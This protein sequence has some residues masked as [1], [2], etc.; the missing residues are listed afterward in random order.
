M[1]EDNLDRQIDLVLQQMAG[2]EGPADLRR[3][4][5]ERVAEPRRRATSRGAVLAAAATILL[6]VAMA[7]VLRRVIVHP[8]ATISAQRDVPTAAATSPPA[9]PSAGASRPARWARLVVRPAPRRNAGPQA[10][11]SLTAGEV[12]GDGGNIEPIEVS[13]LAF[14]P[15]SSGHVT[16]TALRIERLQ[17]EPLAE[18]QP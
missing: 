7:A 4:V 2:G 9:P 17:V 11:E 5:L 12:G 8:P 14:T 3:R 16:V 13:P 18:A 15:M 10:P 6:A 1:T